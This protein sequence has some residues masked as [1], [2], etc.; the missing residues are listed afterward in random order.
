MLGNSPPPRPPKGGREGR[1]NLPP[2][3]GGG[4]RPNPP[5]GGGGNTPNPD[6][7]GG[8]GGSNPPK[9]CSYPDE[10]GGGGG[11][12]TVLNSGREGSP[13]PPT[14]GGGGGGGRILNEFKP[15]RGSIVP[16]IGKEFPVGGGR[17]ETLS[18]LLSV[19][20]LGRPKGGGGGGGSTHPGSVLS[21]IVEFCCKLAGISHFLGN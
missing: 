1:P 9:P 4:G 15:L 19:L 17:M 2:M 16:T 13:V 21:P 3:R 5:I 14:S 11:R 6:G 12:M 18:E 8:S 7:G 20:K 10:E